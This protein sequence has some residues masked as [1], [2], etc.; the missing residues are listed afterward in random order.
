MATDALDQIFDHLAD[1]EFDEAMRQLDALLAAH[2]FAPRL[3]A[4][5]AHLLLATNRPT[6]ATISIKRALALDPD[7]PVI[8]RT[9]AEVWIALQEPAAA[10][11][12]A[13]KALAID[14]DDHEAIIL[15]ARAR[16]LLGQWDEVVS[17]CDYVLMFEPTNEGAAMLRAIALASKKGNRGTLGSEDWEKLA[18]SFPLNAFAR[19]GHAWK[20][21]ERGNRSA[22]EE[23][24][25]QALA[26]NPNSAFAKAGLVTTLKAKYPGYSLLLKYFFRMNE[27]AP[28][29]RTLVAIGGLVGYNILRR[30]AR[31]NPELEPF[32][33]PFL[34]AYAIFVFMT[35]MADPLLNLLL[36]VHPEGRKVLSDEDRLSGWLVGACIGAAIVFAILAETTGWR[37]AFN[38]VVTMAAT[39]FTVAGAFKCEG[40]YRARLLRVASFFAAAGLVSTLVSNPLAGILVAIVVVGMIIS[41]WV[42]RSWSE[43]SYA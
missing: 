10:I 5:R 28:R 2:E 35:W 38:G 27:L 30:S 42:A 3:H 7:D 9:A 21:L 8:H 41:A 14:A 16:T 29:T 1:G 20:L 13:R 4:L 40:I 37:G 39:S 12:A 34:I 32:V 24:F 15:E 43:A 11:A 19:A 6:E 25:H 31:L 26:L 18:R 23:E 33:L 17:R 22:A 36:M